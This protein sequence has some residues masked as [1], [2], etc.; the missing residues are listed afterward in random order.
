MALPLRV[1]SLP[2]KVRVERFHY[3]VSELPPLLS[4]IRL[5]PTD[6]QVELLL[7]ELKKL[8]WYPEETRLLLATKAFPMGLQIAH[9]REG[10]GYVVE[11]DGG[12][13][14]GLHDIFLENAIAFLK[15][16]LA[17]GQIWPPYAD[18][19]LINC[20]AGN[21]GPETRLEIRVEK[22]GPMRVGDM[23]KAFG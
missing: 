11:T 10:W 22:S 20:T 23:S 15:Q 1:L 4:R 2:G 3:D 5:L 8:E 12:A 7:A 6:A 9:P 13:L 14:I 19:G 17:E 21:A 16:Y 18:F